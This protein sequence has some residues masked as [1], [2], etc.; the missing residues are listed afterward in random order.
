VRLKDFSKTKRTRHRSWCGDDA[1]VLDWG[2]IKPHAMVGAK[3]ACHHGDTGL[4]N[5]CVAEGFF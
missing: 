4:L 3:A 2:I 5:N 1:Y